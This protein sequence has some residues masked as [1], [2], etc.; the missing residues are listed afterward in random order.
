[1]TN[2]QKISMNHSIYPLSAFILFG[3]FLNCHAKKTSP[4]ARHKPNVLFLFADDQRAD[5]LGC[6]GIS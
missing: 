3:S 5:A 4:D 1:M 2:L 6:S